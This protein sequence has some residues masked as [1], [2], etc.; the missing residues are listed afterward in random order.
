MS[1]SQVWQKW[2]PEYFRERQFPAF[3]DIWYLQNADLKMALE[4]YATG[5]PVRVLDYGCGGSP[6][7]FL[8]PNARFERADV[9]VFDGVDYAIRTDQSCDAPSAAYDIVLSTQAAEHVPDPETFFAEIFRLIKP[10]GRAII[11]THGTSEDHGLPCD[12]QRWTAEGLRRDLERA[13]FTLVSMDRVTVD[14]RAWLFALICLL[15]W[16][17]PLP[18]RMSR[19]PLRLFTHAVFFTMP[20]INRWADRHLPHQRVV[21]ADEPNRRLYLILAACAE[22]PV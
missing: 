3:R 8:F 6:Y 2:S 18:R 9:V 12:F 17:P 13:G 4:K 14:F 15:I 16:L 20:L 19:M 22:R 21:P 11:T 5:E 7:R 10:G 1:A